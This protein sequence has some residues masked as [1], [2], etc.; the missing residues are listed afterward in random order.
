MKDNTGRWSHWSLPIQFE[1]GEPIASH[2][3]NNLRITEVMY[4]PPD[5]PDGKPTDNDEFEYIELKNTGDEAIDLISLTFIDGIV[6]DFLDSR[7]SILAPGDF[8]LVVGNEAAFLSR[9]GSELSTKIAGEYTGRLSNDGE[10]VSL[11]DFW[12]GSVAEFTYGDGRGWPLAADGGGHSLVPL[13]SALSEQTNGSLNY[14]GNWRASTYI[15][16]SPGMDDPEPIAGVVLN[17]IVTNTGSPSNDW[18]ELYNPTSQ[19]ISLQDWYLS[20]DVTDIE[21]WAIPAVEIYGQAYIS[22]DE[23]TGFHHLTDTGFGLSKSGEQVILSYLPGTFED[24]IVDCIRFKAQQENISLGRYPDGGKYWLRIEPSRDSGNVNPLLDIVIDEIM[25]HPPTETNDEYIELYNPTASR[26]FMATPTNPWRLD[27]AVEYTFDNNV[28]IPS[29]GRLIVVGFDP[30]NEPARLSTFIGTYNTGTLTAGTD[31]VGPWEGNLSNAGE[32]LALEISLAS[33][34]PDDPVSWV[35]VDEVIYSDV[36]PWPDSAD[37]VG[38]ILQRIFADEY[39]S[40]N[41]PDN[42]TAGSPSPGQ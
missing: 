5:P 37:G 21:K 14:A 35:I 34:Q 19:S 4:N 38:D 10:T 33:D 6:F 42:W 31:I 28:S 41:D 25:Y 24:R 27:G 20:D 1:T 16:G 39:H 7:V 15:D 2:I 23:M 11:V 22:F 17:E 32:R 9:Y 30:R 3:L 29:D 8:T 26:A 40:G 36:S 18:I 12:N 13:I